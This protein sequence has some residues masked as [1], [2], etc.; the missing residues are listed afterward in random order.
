[1]IGEIYYAFMAP[2]FFSVEPKSAVVVG[3]SNRFEMNDIFGGGLIHLI[4]WV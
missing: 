1:M 2:A 4:I 3:H